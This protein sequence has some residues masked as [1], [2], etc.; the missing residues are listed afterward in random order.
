V[1]LREELDRTVRVVFM[2]PQPVLGMVGRPEINSL[3]REIRSRLQRVAESLRGL[4]DPA[5]PGPARAAWSRG[6]Y[7]WMSRDRGERRAVAA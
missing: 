5:I 1:V 3:G 4:G 7:T 6:L 2:D